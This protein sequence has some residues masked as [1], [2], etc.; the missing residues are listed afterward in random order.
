M[1]EQTEQKDLPKYPCRFC[2]KRFKRVDHVQRHERRHTKETPYPCSCGQAFSRHDLL[3]RHQKI[4]H[5]IEPA[6]RRKLHHNGQNEKPAGESAS[7]PHERVSGS[8]GN[9]DERHSGQL[10]S[11]IG[12]PPF[13]NLSDSRAGTT[14]HARDVL[15][16]LGI[17]AWN[18][19][20][21]RY[22]SAE[23][24]ASERSNELAHA[25][26][27]PATLRH[28]N[29]ATNVASTTDAGA[30]LIPV[31]NGHNEGPA[32]ALP[33]F[34]YT[35]I[36][37]PGLDFAG[38]QTSNAIPSF[39][40][41]SPA[42]AQSVSATSMS[43]P[44]ERHDGAEL[45]V[46]SR[47]GSPLPSSRHNDT[48]LSVRSDQHDR[49][50][51]LPCWK[52]SPEDYVA[53]QSEHQ[54]FLHK[55]TFRPSEA[56]LELIFAMCSVGSQLRFEPVA[57]ASFFHASKA[58]ILDHQHAVNN[59]PEQPALQENRGLTEDIRR[60]QTMQAL[61]TL[62]CFGSWGPKHLLGETMML[63]SLL[64]G[65]VRTEAVFDL[66]PT[67]DESMPLQDRWTA[68]I[69][70]ERRRRVRNIA[71]CFT[72]LQSLAYN[73]VPPIS[74]ADVQGYTPSSAREW[75]APTAERW[76]EARNATKIVHLPFQKAFAGLFSDEPD[77]EASMSPLGLYAM[78]FGI[79]QCIYYLR[80]GYP[81]GTDHLD[82]SQTTRL[83]KALHRWQVL[84]ERCPESTIVAD[85]SMGPISFNSIACLRM[86]WIRLHLDLGPC[87]HL[88]TRDEA[89][90]ARVFTADR[91]LVR[92]A[93]LTSP[94]LQAIHALSVPVRLGIKFVARSQTMLWSVNQS[95]CTLECAVI[96]SKWLT[97]LGDTI[98]ASSLTYQ[99][100]NIL[101][102]LRDIVLE[103]GAFSDSEVSALS[104]FDDTGIAFNDTSRNM[105]RSPSADPFA[106][107]SFFVDPAVWALPEEPPV[108]STSFALE[109]TA[110]WKR[111]I[112]CLLDTVA[113]LWAEIF[114]NSH[115]FDLVTTIG[116]A[117]NVHANTQE[118]S[119]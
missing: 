88:A 32:D 116:K 25:A 67:D 82:P 3:T 38:L 28:G 16:A 45:N 23:K 17:D 19:D 21:Y 107:L 43:M 54:P 7:H 101:Q 41:V 97:A 114:S 109:D 35:S 12:P 30:T 76:L 110:K 18:L 78:I 63:Q 83:V 112:S 59:G 8:R 33:T 69:E 39:D 50:S 105:Y 117:L 77:G 24:H 115:V 84:W 106:D 72:S 53:I 102:I 2:E 27:P 92:S 71:Y 60:W 87:R 46:F 61:L 99:E 11:G 6:K 118:R 34:D 31:V 64:A 26:T 100:K 95:L 9:D 80:Q 44:S 85:G 10:F 90:I 104:P 14:D 4:V 111:Q 91:S 94:L 98:D 119:S 113:R 37:T 108:P 62:M 36:D 65:L 56:A 49:S 79:L 103:S 22:P 74:S 29:P 58:L 73:T 1:V 68:W 57:G 75:A 52:I 96:I 81:F 47:L 93:E 20:G 5:G 48:S 42:A 55:A 40:H 66:Q 15:N 86:A 89:T 51:S 13:N 70:H